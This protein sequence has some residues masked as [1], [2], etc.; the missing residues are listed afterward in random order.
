M[1]THTPGPSRT[2]GP[3]QNEFS[4]NGMKGNFDIPSNLLN[5]MQ[6]SSIPDASHMPVKSSINILYVILVI[7]LIGGGGAAFWFYYKNKLPKGEIN[8]GMKG[9]P[10]IKGK[11]INKGP[12]GNKVI[13]VKKK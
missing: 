5:E 4:T 1:Y 8:K 9:N 3:N 6:S 12:K 7:L 2:P 13:T 11:Q 10:V